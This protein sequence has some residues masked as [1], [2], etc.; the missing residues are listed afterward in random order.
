M[1]TQTE[2]SQRLHRQTEGLAVGVH[3]HRGDTLGVHTDRGV[4]TLGVNKD[5][6]G[7]NEREHTLPLLSPLDLG[8]PRPYH[9]YN[10]P[11][12]ESV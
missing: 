9:A 2:G 7:P 11:L 6:G 12:L 10:R 3:T 1:Y 4:F 5:R 8:V